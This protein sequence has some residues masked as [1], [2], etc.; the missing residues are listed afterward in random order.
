MSH[1]RLLCFRKLNKLLPLYPKTQNY[2]VFQKLL[3]SL[4]TGTAFFSSLVCLP[5]GVILGTLLTIC[6]SGLVDGR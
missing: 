4:N 2:C 1:A 5:A 6:Y 3:L